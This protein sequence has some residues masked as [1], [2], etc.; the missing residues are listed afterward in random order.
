MRPPLHVGGVLGH[1]AD[2]AVL[3]PAARDADVV[4]SALLAA[5]AK[6]SKYQARPLDCS[7]ARAALGEEK[8]RRAHAGHKPTAVRVK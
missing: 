8:K 4:T 5:D 1:S 2:A 3:R 6:S 7:A